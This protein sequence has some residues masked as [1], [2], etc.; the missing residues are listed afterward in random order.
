MLTALLTPMFHSALP[1]A[2]QV[3]GTIGVV[4]VIGIIIATIIGRN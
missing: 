3:G 2:A 1:V 4:A